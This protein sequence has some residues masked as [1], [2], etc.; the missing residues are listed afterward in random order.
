MLLPSAAR[1]SGP[2][3]RTAQF[4]VERRC[5]EYT[6]GGVV[7]VPVGFPIVLWV[8][9]PEEQNRMPCGGKTWLVAPGEVE[10]VTGRFPVPP[11]KRRGTAVCEHMGHLIE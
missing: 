9:V 5:T 7:P 1:V 2:G 10:R 6:Q 4:V 11:G 3:E 8:V